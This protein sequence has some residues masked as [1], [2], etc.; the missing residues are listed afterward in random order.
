MCVSLNFNTNNI[1]VY[2]YLYGCRTCSGVVRLA[3]RCVILFIKYHSDIWFAPRVILSLSDGNFR[4]ITLLIFYDKKH[5][6]GVIFIRIVLIWHTH[7][8][9]MIKDI[10][11]KS[12]HIYFNPSHEGAKKNDLKCCSKRSF[13]PRKRVLCK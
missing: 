10:S 9:I 4:E 2:L 13:F 7:V 11:H 5:L 8:P 3:Q 12:C 1:T 6:R